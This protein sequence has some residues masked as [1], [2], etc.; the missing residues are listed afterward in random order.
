MRTQE[1]NEPGHLQMKTQPRKRVRYAPRPRAWIGA[2]FPLG[3]RSPPSAPLRV[4]RRLARLHSAHEVRPRICSAG[5]EGLEPPSDRV[6]KG[7]PDSTNP[8]CLTR[9][10]GVSVSVRTGSFQE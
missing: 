4:P 5:P 9:D 6:Q 1:A 2:P 7:V 3:D 10:T 8:S